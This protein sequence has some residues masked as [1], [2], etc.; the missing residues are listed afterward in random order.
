MLYQQN[1]PLVQESW[2]RWHNNMI[3]PVTAT[4]PADLRMWMRAVW[5]LPAGSPGSPGSSSRSWT[6]SWWWKRHWRRRWWGGCVGQSSRRPCLA[7]C[8]QQVSIDTRFKLPTLCRYCLCRTPGWRCAGARWRRCRPGGWRPR[9]G[10]AATPAPP[11]ACP[12]H[13]ARCPG[14]GGVQQTPHKEP[15]SLHLCWI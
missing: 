12:P 3:K 5:K 2:K 7:S 14:T 9:G 6:S 8:Q 10:R 11:R 1:T 15:A 13:P 4:F